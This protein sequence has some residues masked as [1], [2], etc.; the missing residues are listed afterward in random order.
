M[1]LQL[2]KHLQSA[3]GPMTTLKP[4]PTPTPTTTPPSIDGPEE[5]SVL[6]I[7]G[8]AYL[9]NDAVHFRAASR[10]LHHTFRMAQELEDLL[11]KP[12]MAVLRERRGRSLSAIR[13][14]VE[15]IVDSLFKA[16]NAAADEEGHGQVDLKL[17]AP[18]EYGPT[19]SGSGSGSGSACKQTLLTAGYFI[20]CLSNAGLWPNRAVEQD[21]TYSVAE[22]LD[23][24]EVI[25]SYR[26]PGS[27]C[28]KARCK[29]ER[30]GPCR[31]VDVR[32]GLMG[33]VERRR[34]GEL[35]GFCLGCVREGWCGRAWGRGCGRHGMGVEVEMGV[36]VGLDG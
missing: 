15:G 21:S 28:T 23:R 29:D 12:L 3:Q 33:V 19:G 32:E 24:L 27:K 5:L 10:N 11:P 26:K 20:G 30:C 4:L 17:T 14:E 31:G 13:A 18:D 7:T 35:V 9:F 8:I 16:P 1:S 2:E 25:A 36:G 22:Y 6:E 34:R